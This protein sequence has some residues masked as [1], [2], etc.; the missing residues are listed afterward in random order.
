[1]N[2]DILFPSLLKL[3]RPELFLPLE[4]RD[5][6][7]IPGKRYRSPVLGK[8][9]RAGPNDDCAG[10]PTASPGCNA[11]TTSY[12]AYITASGIDYTTCVGTCATTGTPANPNNSQTATGG[13]GLWIQ[14]SGVVTSGSIRARWVLRKG[15][16]KF[17][18]LYRDTSSSPFTNFIGFASDIAVVDPVDCNLTLNFTSVLAACGTYTDSWGTFYGCVF[19]FSGSA[20]V[21]FSPL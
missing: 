18:L 2:A 6:V 16:N 10:C 5:G 17:T 19:G 11:N 13:S 3:W 7:T 20:V 1:M 21:T 8:R 4:C 12:T 14:N 15:T 9:T